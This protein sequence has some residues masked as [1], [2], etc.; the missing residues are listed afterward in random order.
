[1]RR[2]APESRVPA[3][4]PNTGIINW[5]NPK[6]KA[7]RKACRGVTD[8]RRTPTAAATA[9]ASMASPTE[10]PSNSSQFT[11]RL[12][13]SARP[14]ADAFRGSAPTTQSWGFSNPQSLIQ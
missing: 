6:W 1:M 7:S 9:K 2:Y 3:S 13:K 14:Q 5:N 11:Q 4:Q 12:P 10:M 8:S